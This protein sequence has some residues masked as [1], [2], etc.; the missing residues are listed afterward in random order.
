MKTRQGFVSNSSSSSF[1]A[2]MVQN[3]D[4]EEQLI[5]KLNLDETDP[6]DWGW[7]DK[8]KELGFDESNYGIWTHSETGLDVSIDEY[9]E[10]YWIG[11]QIDNL[12]GKDMRI[13]ECKLF[14]VDK[15]KE[16]GLEVNSSQITWDHGK[17]SSG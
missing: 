4:I 11:F 17:T 14:L 2:V 16:L 15:I 6:G 9:G 12:L 7:Y 3:D 5:K 8:L 10:I 13:S 1:I